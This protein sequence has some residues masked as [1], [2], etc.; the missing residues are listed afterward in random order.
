ML[1]FYATMI[2]ICAFQFGLFF[3]ILNNWITAILIT[4]E[5]A[6]ILMIVRCSRAG[7]TLQ[8]SKAEKRIQL[9][10][11]I[12]CALTCTAASGYGIA[13]YVTDN[14]VVFQALHIVWIC[15]HGKRKL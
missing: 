4:V 5:Y 11:L 15:S 2:R 14:V 3:S 6:V 10:A 13:G 7:L 8:Q 1:L 12:I 9:Q